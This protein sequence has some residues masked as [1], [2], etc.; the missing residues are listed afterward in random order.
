MPD[1]ASYRTPAI[2]AWAAGGEDAPRAMTA[3]SLCSHGISR[4][5][6]SPSPRNRQPRISPAL[7]GTAEKR[8]LK[9]RSVAVTP[10]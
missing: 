7:E 4:L 2:E 1:G 3:D 10:L 5:A 6:P 9:L 8:E